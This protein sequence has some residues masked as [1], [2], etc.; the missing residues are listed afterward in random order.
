MI[1]EEETISSE[2]IYEGKILN[3]RR[4]R[5]RVHNGQESYREIVE[6]NGGVAIAA[7]TPEGKMVLVRQYRKAAGK[8]LLEVPAGKIEKDE[9]S[10]LEVAI[11]ELKEET[12]YTAG[13]MTLI[14]HFYASV[15]YSM[16]IIYLYLALHLSPG[17]TSFDEHE[18]IEIEEYE[19][20]DLKKMIKTGAI[21]DSKTIAAILLTEQELNGE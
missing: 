11:R 13:Q 10:H 16:E 1:F 4:D 8:A 12:G 3:L 19:I 15:G 20:K 2:R 18:L 6:H 5:V 17:E 7:V 9:S 14:T 21:C